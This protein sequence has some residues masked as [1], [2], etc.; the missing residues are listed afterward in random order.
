MRATLHFPAPALGSPEFAA[1]Q[2]LAAILT[3]GEQAA[4]SRAAGASGTVLSAGAGVDGGDPW[5]GF[6]VSLEFPV[7][8]AQPRAGVNGV[9]AH[10]VSLLDG[11]AIAHDLPAAR[12]SRFVEEI[13]L[14]EKMHYYGLMR[15]D[16]LGSGD[17]ALAEAVLR[18]TRELRTADVVSALAAVLHSGRCVVTLTGP[19]VGNGTEALEFPEVPAR[20]QI[21]IAADTADAPIPA[22]E[23]V[24]PD[25]SNRRLLFRNGFTLIQHG[26]PDAR[27]FAAHVLLR[28][29]SALERRSGVPRGT[30]DIV[31]RMMELGTADRTED[32]LRGELHGLGATLKVTDTDWIPYDDYYFS[33]EF[34]YVRLETIDS[35]GVP[36]LELLGDVLRTPRF[37]D[38]ALA[39]AREA[40]AARAERDGRS[41]RRTATD[42]FLGALG[43][44]HPEAGGIYGDPDALRGV[45]LD[46]VRRHHTLMTSPENVVLCVSSS[47]PLS[48]V[49][50]A[51][52]RI[53]PDGARPAPA[54]EA[55]AF[56]PT[57][58]DTRADTDT[59]ADAGTPA[60]SPRRIITEVNP[61]EAAEQAW[62]IL[63][64]AVE[65]PEPDH[66]ALRLA[67]A[68]LSERLAEELREREGLAYSIGAGARLE[69][70]G[71]YVRMSAGTRPENLDAMETGMMRVAAEML[72]RSPGQAELDGARNRAEGRVRMRRLTRM[73]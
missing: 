46:D 12:L 45:T 70:A 42:G 64:D 43:T 37:T 1:T 72:T 31:H 52:R 6:S 18:K 5:S 8:N 34:S 13:G 63:G 53:F 54:E 36:A 55:G 17:P 27:T 62:V 59:P 24:I 61:G 38:E 30:S 10:L 39:K 14:H 29:R 67:V 15:A 51:V 41:A 28:D 66:A 48:V 26:S 25:R 56:I 60:G 58:A 4:V 19:G 3:N 32:E 44:N 57:D 68:I 65:V 40:A 71:T 33:P 7:E 73:G 49:D 9:L 69:G 47:L 11:R 16:L 35:F 20:D 2:L 22:P 50:Q 23:E 21:R